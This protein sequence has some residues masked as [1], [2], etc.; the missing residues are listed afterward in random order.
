MMILGAAGF[1]SGIIS[2]MGIGGGTILIP[3]LM[4]FGDMTQQQA[5]SINIIY[6]I[7]TAVVA[8]IKHK[9]DGNIEMKTVK[10]IIFWGIAGALAGAFIATAIDSES[11]KKLFGIFLLVMGIMEIFK[12][13]E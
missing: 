10:P 1:I 7:P 9:K 11:L 4:F 3:A 8:L 12:K 6:F 2:G 13:K 5:Q